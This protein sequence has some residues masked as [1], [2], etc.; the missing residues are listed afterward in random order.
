MLDQI[1]RLEIFVNQEL[2]VAIMF[3][4]IFIKVGGEG[5]FTDL[6]YH[7]GKVKETIKKES[8]SYVENFKKDAST[9][10]NIVLHETGK[11]NENLFQ[12][13]LKIPAINETIKQTLTHK[14]EHSLSTF[15]A[16]KTSQ[17]LQPL[18]TPIAFIDEDWDYFEDSNTETTANQSYKMT[19]FNDDDEDSDVQEGSPNSINDIFKNTKQTNM[20]KLKLKAKEDIKKCTITAEIEAEGWRCTALESNPLNRYL[21][22]HSN[23]SDMNVSNLE[24]LKQEL[25]NRVRESNLE[26]LRLLEVE[27]SRKLFELGRSSFQIA[28]PMSYSHPFRPNL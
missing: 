28:F 20:R 13:K 24:I 14:T 23:I 11:I 6:N 10:S 2:Q 27:L 12:G 15:D 25:E 16:N 26:L 22:K 21:A 1:W 19:Y 18:P 7:L 3:K 5:K 4:N 8:E 9:V 17:E